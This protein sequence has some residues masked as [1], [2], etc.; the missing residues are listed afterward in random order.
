MAVETAADRAA[1]LD[2]DYGFAEAATH[3]NEFGVSST[4][5]GIFDNTYSSVNIGIGEV[6]FSESNPTF[7]GRTAD[8]TD[9]R[10]G[11]HLEL[12]SVTWII[13]EIMP[14]GTGFTELTLERE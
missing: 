6:D 3:I 2:V 10:Y 14:D 4:V 5:N 1:M 12:N 11:D 9:I 13:R 8:F 7:I